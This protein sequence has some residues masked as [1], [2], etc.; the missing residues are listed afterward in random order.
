MCARDLL[1]LLSCQ[2]KLDYVRPAHNGKTLLNFR[3]NRCWSDPDAV[4]KPMIGRQI[5]C[6]WRHDNI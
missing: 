4:N 3:L 1:L 5:F 6:I 2:Q